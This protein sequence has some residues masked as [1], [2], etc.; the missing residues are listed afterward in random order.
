MHTRESLKVDAVRLGIESGD[1]I[2]VHASF[3][4]ISREEVFVFWDQLNHQKRGKIGDADCHHF[5]IREFLD[6]ISE[7]VK[8]D[9]KRFF[10][11]Y[12]D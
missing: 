2:F 8:A 5:F 1:T 7:A 11:M 9:V 12:Q 4:R 6:I 10:K 3:N